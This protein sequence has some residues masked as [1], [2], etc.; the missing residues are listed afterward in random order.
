MMHYMHLLKQYYYKS[1]KNISRKIIQTKSLGTF[2]S[3]LKD[4]YVL[5]D[6]LNYLLFL[7]FH[8]LEYIV[9]NV[10]FSKMKL[11][12]WDHVYVPFFAVMINIL[13]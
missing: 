4:L 9:F 6:R 13:P 8:Y 1:E 5:D 2:F 7:R 3:P 12:L 10:L 11:D